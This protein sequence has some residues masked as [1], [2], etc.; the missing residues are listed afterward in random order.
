MTLALQSLPF[1][2]QGLLVTL[3]VSALVVLLVAA[4]GRGWARPALKRTILGN[5]A[6]LS[7]PRSR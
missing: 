2:L 4:L 3:Q 1:L 5:L 7:M 6:N